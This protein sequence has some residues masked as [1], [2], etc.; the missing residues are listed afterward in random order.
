MPCTVNN[1]FGLV[2]GVTLC[3]NGKKYCNPATI[4]STAGTQLTGVS[5]TNGY[6]T[7]TSGGAG[8]ATAGNAA[9]K[10]TGTGGTIATGSG[11]RIT[12]TTTT[13]SAA[14]KGGSGTTKTSTAP[15]ATSSDPKIPEI[16][17]ECPEFRNQTTNIGGNSS[18]TMAVGPKAA[19]PTAPMLFYWHGTGS[20][21]GEYAMMDGAVANGITSQGGVLISYD[22]TSGSGDA[23]CSGTMLFDTGTFV[24]TDQLVACAIKNY[25]VDPHKIYTAGCSAGGLFAA[26]MSA[27]RSSYVAAAAPNSGGFVMPQIFDSTHT[28]SLMTRHGAPGVDVVGVD[29]STTSKTADDAF[30]GRGGFVINCN[31]GGGHCGGGGLSPQV[32]EFFQ[33]HPY[34]VDPYPWKDGLPADFPSG[35]AIY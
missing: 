22:G 17:G 31:H 25:N 10:P 18:F 20:F 29:F 34:G 3:V 2:T 15:I 27:L 8:K 26:C 35:C 1:G 30:K 28:P 23:M 9:K 24:Y 4:T 33:A 6:A 21:A 32:W 14:G 19:G 13:A 12:T 11:G 5:G 16:T 7:R